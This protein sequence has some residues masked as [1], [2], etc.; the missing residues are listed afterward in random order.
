MSQVESQTPSPIQA[1]KSTMFGSTIT[2]KSL[3][4]SSHV[5][6][7][8]GSTKP[9]KEQLVYQPY[10]PEQQIAIT[11]DRPFAGRQNRQV[12][13]QENVHAEGC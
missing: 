3:M 12:R 11:T 2:Y 8:P 5:E 6:A 13:E 4:S 10:T 7:S 1:V 9:P